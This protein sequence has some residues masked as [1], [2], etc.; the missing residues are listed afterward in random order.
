MK[1]SFALLVALASVATVSAKQTSSVHLRFHKAAMDGACTIE[2]E[3][4]CDG[5]NWT[6]STCCKDSN[7]ECR[8]DDKGQNVKRCQKKNAGGNNT[9]PS[10]PTTPTEPADSSDSSDDWISWIDVN[11]DCTPI[12]AFC[13]GDSICIYHSEYYAQCKPYTL[14]QGDL[15][16]QDDGTNVWFYEACPS[17]QSCQQQGTDYRCKSTKHHKRH[18]HKSHAKAAMDGACTIESESQCDGQNWSMS[19]CCKDSNYECR[20][21]D[22]GQN[23][24]RCQKK[25]AGGNTSAPSQPSTPSQPSS[26]SSTKWVDVYGDCTAANADCK[27]ESYCIYHSAYYAQCKPDILGQGELCGQNDGTNVWKYDYCPSG[28]TCQQQGTDFRCK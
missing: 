3:S 21:D 15:C 2:S 28:Q 18:H 6:M 14:G 19:T 17:G 10:Q 26:D 7:Y 9:T 27:G 22:F 16:G 1:S 25:N 11:G 20:M 13:K 24:K 5:Q 8:M 23:V 12:D 4:Q